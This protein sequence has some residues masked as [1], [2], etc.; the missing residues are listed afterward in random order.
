MPQVTTQG[1]DFRDQRCWAA[2]QPRVYS[3]RDDH[4]LFVTNLHL[5]ANDIA[6]LNFTLCEGGL[7]FHKLDH[8]G[9]DLFKKFQRGAGRPAHP[10]VYDS[11]QIADLH[12]SL[13]VDLADAIKL[14][15]SRI[16]I[17]E[18]NHERVSVWL[19]VSLFVFRANI[20]E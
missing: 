8:A 11:G 10:F 20:E 3:I 12:L 17:L 13:Y 19:G 15:L 5:E 14:L 7:G 6:V 18:E 9:L 16:E 2:C 1:L 4:S